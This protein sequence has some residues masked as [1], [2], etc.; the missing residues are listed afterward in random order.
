MQVIFA[1]IA[2]L[3]FV[4]AAATGSSAL[5]TDGTPQ[6]G[7]LIKIQM[8]LESRPERLVYLVQVQDSANRTVF[9]SWKELQ[10]DQ[11]L[12]I[13]WHPM[14]PGTYAAQAFAWTSFESPVALAQAYVQTFSVEPGAACSGEARCFSGTVTKVTDG[15]TIRVDDIAVRL[16]LVNTPER[17]QAGYSEA[18]NFTAGICP[19]GSMATV[20][21]DDGQT[22]GSYGRVVAKVFCSGKML[23]EELLAAGHAAIYESFCSESEFG[24]EEWAVRHGC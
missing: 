8:N 1:A 20:D 12:S 6:V 18:T 19:I 2:L 9:L 5:G 11:A 24:R 23:N 10:G 4:M 16:A 15:D 13:D 17:G 22:E 3:A 21:E 14:E 7:D